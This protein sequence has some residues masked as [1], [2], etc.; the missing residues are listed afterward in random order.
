MNGYQ[1]F[2]EGFT[3]CQVKGSPVYPILLLY[4]GGY[5]LIIL[6]KK[7]N[8]GKIFSPK[9]KPKYQHF[10]R[11][12]HVL[13]VFFKHNYFLIENFLFFWHLPVRITHLNRNI[14]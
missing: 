8:I 11:I 1:E 10:Y 6:K 5:L 9:I 12:N 14:V 4:F 7:Y 2:S 13:D 3:D